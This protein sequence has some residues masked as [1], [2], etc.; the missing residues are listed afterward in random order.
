MYIA[1]LGMLTIFLWSSIIESSAKRNRDNCPSCA[2]LAAKIEIDVVTLWNS[3]IGIMEGVVVCCPWSSSDY[4]KLF[5]VTSMP[6]SL[7]GSGLK[8]ICAIWKGSL[9]GRKMDLWSTKISSHFQ[10]CEQVLSSTCW[11]VEFEF[12]IGVSQAIA[13]VFNWL[14]Y[15]AR[16]RR[17]EWSKFSELYIPDSRY[18]MCLHIPSDT[19]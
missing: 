7:R 3:C 17:E 6:R 5:F 8:C 10:R 9:S 19:L 11:R 12:E 13:M 18:G 14:N 1:L 16:V 4:L 15:F 2:L